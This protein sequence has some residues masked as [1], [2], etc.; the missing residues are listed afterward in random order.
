MDEQ[1]GLSAG[2]VEAEDTVLRLDTIN[3]MLVLTSLP[4]SYRC[5]PIRITSATQREACGS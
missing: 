1:F 5:A 2:E 3:F 4:D